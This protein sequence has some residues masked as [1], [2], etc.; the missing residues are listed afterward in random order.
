MLG[1]ALATFLGAF[2]LFQVQPLMGKLILPWYGGGPAVWTTC[3]LFFQVLLLA[4]YGYAHWVAVRLRPRSQAVVHGV[5]LV[6]AAAVLPI[7]PGARWKPGSLADPTWHILALLAATVGLPY[8]VL[9]ATAPLVQ[10][11]FSRTCP[12][13]SPYRLYALSNA[14]ALLALLSFPFVMEPLV[15]AR[16][17]AIGWSLAFVAYAALMGWCVLRARAGRTGTW[18]RATRLRCSGGSSGS[19]CLP[20]GPCCCWRSRTSSAPTSPWCRS[21]G[22]CPWRSTC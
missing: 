22:C 11:W 10:A 6:A 12:G 18:A 7:L 20:V 16:R 8:L 1:Y 3:M 9:S 21:C 14:G 17:Q 5:L 15:G 2:L 13:R 19:R 4:G